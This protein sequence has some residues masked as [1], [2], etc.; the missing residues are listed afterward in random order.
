MVRG[1]RGLEALSLFSKGQSYV[2]KEGL[3]PYEDSHINALMF[4]I[5]ILLQSTIWI[6]PI[7]ILPISDKAICLSLVDR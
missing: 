3:D 5:W 4:P 1:S 7:W 6:F 2:A